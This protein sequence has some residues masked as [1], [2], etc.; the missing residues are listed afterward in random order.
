MNW[1]DRLLL[2]L[3]R[4]LNNC[5]REYAQSGVDRLEI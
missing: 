3:K 5:Y 2:S 4:D 1:L